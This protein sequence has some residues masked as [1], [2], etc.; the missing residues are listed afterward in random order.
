M[1]PAD[2]DEAKRFFS[3]LFGEAEQEECFQIFA[4]APGCTLKPA[5][6][7]R[8]IDAAASGLQKNNIAGAGIYFMVNKG[9]GKGRSSDHVQRVRAFFVDLDGAPLDPVLAAPVKPHVV[10]ETSPGRYHAF[11]RVHQCPLERFSAVQVALVKKFNADP[12][13]IDLPRVMRVPGF[14]NMKM[15]PFQVKII[16]ADEHAAALSWTQFVQQQGLELDASKPKYETVTF[17]DG[18]MFPKGQR[19][20]KMKFV[21]ARLRHAGMAN[22]DLFDALDRVNRARCDPPLPES[23]LHGFVKWAMQRVSPQDLA[24]TRLPRKEHKQIHQPQKILS[25]K[26]L[27]MTKFPPVKWIVKDLLPAGLTILAG[28]PKVGKSWLI[29]NLTWA[30]ASGEQALATFPT[31]QGDVLNLALE[32]PPQRFQFRMRLISQG[33]DIPDRAF[34]TNEWPRMPDGV[35]FLETWLKERGKGN[36]RLVVVDTLAKFRTKGQRFEAGYE[37]DYA[38]IADLQVLARDWGIALILVHHERKQ[39]GDDDYDR[40]SGTSAITGAADTVW[41]L[42]RKDRS[43]MAGILKISGRD[44]SDREYA[45]EWHEKTGTW[46]YQGTGEE[47]R[48][49]GFENEILAVFQDLGR[50]CSAREVADLIGKQRTNVSAYITKMVQKGILERSAMQGKYVVAPKPEMDHI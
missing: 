6:R 45:L 5:Y 29:Q 24:K 35:D 27:H 38:D 37:R 15:E 22:Q 2:A 20:S 40:V 33:K 23:E 3:V 7:Y 28:R 4:E 39:A 42:D 34:F 30:I 11:W 50:P 9:D 8:Q 47:A 32:D 16:H 26:E 21:V 14:W 48:L 18:E 10:T 36:V 13:C 43:K 31:N 12:A 41:I 44:I 25:W 49:K 19:H 1:F 46:I 17:E